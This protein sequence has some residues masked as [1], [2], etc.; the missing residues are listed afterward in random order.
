[1]SPERRR[2]REKDL[3]LHLDPASDKNKF[4]AG[5]GLGRYSR[6]LRPFMT[7]QTNSPNN[8]DDKITEENQTKTNQVKI[9]DCVDRIE[10][11]NAIKSDPGRKSFEKESR[12]LWSP[13]T[14][15]ANFYTADP[16]L[17]RRLVLH[18]EFSVRW[19]EAAQ[20]SDAPRQTYTVASS[21]A[22]DRW[23]GEPVY[24]LEGS[25]PAG[26]LTVK[27]SP[28]KQSGHAEIITQRVLD[29]D[30]RKDGGKND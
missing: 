22:V 16:G 23:D 18:P 1:M 9:A 5:P 8:F 30:P 17:M 3:L 11:L 4:D 28:R 20:S 12:V 27:Q 29:N 24:S 13:R 2:R 19:F 10:L 15:H 7:P 6:L 25:L 14:D 21:N 26:V